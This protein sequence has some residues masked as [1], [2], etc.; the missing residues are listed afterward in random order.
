LQ[1]HAFR[2]RIVP[3]SSPPKCSLRSAA[4]VFDP[5]PFAQHTASTPNK[6][7]AAD[8]TLRNYGEMGTRTAITSQSSVYQFFAMIGSATGHQAS[9][10]A[11]CTISTRTFLV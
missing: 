7:V 10:R 3:A 6:S 4:H 1:E 9:N 11:C 5:R 8:D 2:R